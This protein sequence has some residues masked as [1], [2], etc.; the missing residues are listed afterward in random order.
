MVAGEYV[1]DPIICLAFH[2]LTI[3]ACFGFDEKATQVVGCVHCEEV[4]LF[5]KAALA[6]PAG[7]RRGVGLA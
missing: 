5:V 1:A 4:L 6:K 7:C 3:Q 2:P